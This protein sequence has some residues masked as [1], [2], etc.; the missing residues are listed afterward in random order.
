M[1]GDVPQPPP[2]VYMPTAESQATP[3]T[4]IAYDKLVLFE[5]SANLY[6]SWGHCWRDAIRMPQHVEVS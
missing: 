4:L 1:D 6:G 5:L 2:A 3:S